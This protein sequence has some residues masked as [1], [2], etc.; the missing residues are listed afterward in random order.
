M[1]KIGINVVTTL[2]NAP[3]NRTGPYLRQI[4]SI[5]GYQC[6]VLSM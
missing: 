2:Q 3:A 4:I 1:D 5:N 6:I